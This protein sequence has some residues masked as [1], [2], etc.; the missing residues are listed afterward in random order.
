MTILEKLNNNVNENTSELRRL[1][2]E[3]RDIEKK[4]DRDTKMLSLYKSIQMFN[5][6]NSSFIVKKHADNCI[7]VVELFD[8]SGSL[9]TR[10]FT[11]EHFKNSSTD[12]II[13][14]LEE[15][16]AKYSIVQQ[17]VG[18]KF[19]ILFEGDRKNEL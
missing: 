13:A 16:G 5:D 10:I 18:D 17:Q 12:E 7:Q 1:K 6:D 4:N 14:M 8:F 11:I 19:D 3:I 9:S 15:I 2:R